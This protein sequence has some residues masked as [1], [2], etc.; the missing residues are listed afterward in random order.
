MS[1]AT[2]LDAHAPTS[3]KI[4]SRL[5]RNP[6]VMILT[7]SPLLLSFINPQAKAIIDKW[8]RME[9]GGPRVGIPNAI[10]TFCLDLLDTLDDRREIGSHLPYQMDRNIG[11]DGLYVSLK[12]VGLPRSSEVDQSRMCILL[13]EL[14]VERRKRS[15]A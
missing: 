13:E 12:G 7:H 8:H 4:P 14:A 15:A 10:V 3:D 11:T 2:L 1:Y 5:N 9:S 6:G